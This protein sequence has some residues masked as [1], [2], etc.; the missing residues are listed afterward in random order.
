M[1]QLQKN[2]F[3]AYFKATILLIAT[4]CLGSI[5]ASGVARLLE[6]TKEPVVVNKP[7][8]VDS[9]DVFVLKNAIREGREILPEDV[10]VVPQNKDKVPRGAVKTYQQI[11]GRNVKLE[12]PKGTLLIDEYFTTRIAT[13]ISKGFIPP[14]YHSVPILIQEP[15]TVATSSH[16]AVLPGDQVDVIIVQKDTE[17]GDESDEFVLLEKIPVLDALWE[18]IGNTPKQEKKGTVTLLLSDSQRKNLQEEYQEGTKIRLRIC[19]PDEMQTVSQP[20]PQDPADLADSR[21]FYQTDSQPDLISQSLS[22]DSLQNGIEIIFHGNDHGKT[23]ITGQALRP[24]DQNEPLIPAFRGIPTE[25]YGEVNSP[26]AQVSAIGKSQ[27]ANTP[28]EIRP[29]PGYLSFYDASGQYGNARVQWHVTVP[30]SPVVYEAHPGFET[31]VRGVYREGSVY[32]SAK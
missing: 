5:I 21:I 14:G 11:E 1:N 27:T 13:S 16:S 10:I 20:Q 8:S 19:S 18:E 31:Q 28:E 25:S 15:A 4:F 9:R 24:V 23:F 7:D 32:Y 2:A 3:A 29:V 26:V 12:L 17:T 6:K 22:H 30:R